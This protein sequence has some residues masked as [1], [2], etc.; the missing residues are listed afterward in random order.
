MSARAKARA[1]EL[2]DEYCIKEPSDLNVREIANGEN[3]MIEEEDTQGHAG[4]I[5]IDKEGGLITI[6]KKIKEEGRKNF[7]I[8]HEVGHFCLEKAREYF[9]KKEDFYYFLSTQDP[10]KEANIFAAELLMPEE[11]VKEYVKWKYEAKETVETAAQIFNTSMSSMAIRY[12]EHGRFPIAVIFSQDTR[13]RWSCINKDFPFQ[14][15]E[16]GQKVN[17]FSKAYDFYSGNEI[18]T[19][20]NDILADAWF[21]KD[22]N[23]KKE[24]YL[25]EQNVPMKAYNGVLTYVW[26][27]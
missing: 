5:F 10:E 7:T 14:W 25:Y 20:V 22:F 21:L 12:A 8:A 6:D 17:A 4:R 13:V 3:L 11:W 26:D 23:Y 1:R 19:D 16:N 27:E 15:I 24:K 2:L 9:C 18:N